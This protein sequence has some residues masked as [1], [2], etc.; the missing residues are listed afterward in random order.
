MTMQ[1]TPSGPF[2]FFPFPFFSFLHQGGCFARRRCPEKTGHSQNSALTPIGKFPY[3]RRLKDLST[4]MGPHRGSRRRRD[5][6]GPRSVCPPHGSWRRASDIP[7]TPDLTVALAVGVAKRPIAPGKVPCPKPPW[8]I[9][10]PGAFFCAAGDLRQ[11]LRRR[12]VGGTRR[13]GC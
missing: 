11:G 5:L 6:S 12:K 7:G 9:A 3:S 4:W 1:R 13:L 10:F 2:P 8:D